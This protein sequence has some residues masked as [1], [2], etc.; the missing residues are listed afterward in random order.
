MK[1][2]ILGMMAIVI[3]VATT[4]CSESD[5]RSF[6]KKIISIN[7]NYF[8]ESKDSGYETG[9]K[10]YDR[11]GIY[12]GYVDIDNIVY[13]ETRDDIEFCGGEIVGICTSTGEGVCDVA[14]YE[15]ITYSE[16]VTLIPP[17]SVFEC[18]ERVW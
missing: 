18:G 15:R 5:G 11:H 8:G 13:R 9:S 7:G 3:A 17:Y 4:G 6:D 2:S 12:V 1:K 10:L 14:N 16:G